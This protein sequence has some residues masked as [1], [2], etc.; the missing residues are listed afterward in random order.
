MAEPGPFI[1]EQNVL[2][3]PTFQRARTNRLYGTI[4]MNRRH[5]GV[6]GSFTTCVALEPIDSVI[7]LISSLQLRQSSR[8]VHSPPGILG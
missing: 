7:I 2:L 3:P 5:L 1:Y 4:M 8:R 6:R